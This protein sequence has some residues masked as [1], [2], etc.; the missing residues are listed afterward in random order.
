MKFGE[1]LKQVNY[2]VR[3]G[4]KGKLI[5]KTDKGQVEKGLR[6]YKT[7]YHETTGALRKPELRIL[8]A[9][10][11]VAH[12]NIYK[13]TFVS[14]DGM[15]IETK[16]QS[17]GWYPVET[18]HGT[19]NKKGWE[20]NNIVYVVPDCQAYLMKE[21]DLIEFRNFIKE[22]ERDLIK[23]VPEKIKQEI[24]TEIWGQFDEIIEWAQR[25]K[26]DNLKEKFRMPKFKKIDEHNYNKMQLISDGWGIVYSSE[27]EIY[28]P[29]EYE[30]MPIG[31]KKLDQ[32]I[33]QHKI[34]YVNEYLEYESASQYFGSADYFSKWF[35]LKGHIIEAEIAEN[36]DNG[37]V[38][39]VGG[40]VKLSKGSIVKHR[41]TS[42][43]GEQVYEDY[44][45]I[46]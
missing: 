11:Q 26:F 33:P 27:L 46:K 24:L 12:N 9:I 7:T 40:T 2:Y 44:Y 28:K 6:E 31:W 36:L 1:F 30:P 18:E 43:L 41:Y 21:P 45:E 29:S 10:N 3:K 8:Q 16:W 37:F 32:Q 38:C 39:G 23:N 34:E 22:K 42:N 35:L 19:K 4:E 13:I 25:A 20:Y 5:F 17:P 14:D 15:S